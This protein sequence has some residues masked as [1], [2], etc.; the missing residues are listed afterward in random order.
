[1]K[2]LPDDLDILKVYVY[3]LG[4]K[5]RGA[6]ARTS[7]HFD[8]SDQ[9][10]SNIVK[11][12]RQTAPVTPESTNLYDPSSG[13]YEAHKAAEL[14]AWRQE[15]QR[16]KDVALLDRLLLPTEPELANDT[17]SASQSVVGIPEQNANGPECQQTELKSAKQPTKRRNA[18]DGLALVWLGIASVMTLCF[19]LA[20]MVALWPAVLMFCASLGSWWNVGLARRI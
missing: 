2:R 16:R 18:N 19:F 8:C 6:L 14:A 10:V 1:M 15:R 5:Q 12:H 7:R 13:A 3:E 17:D 9:H 4:Q 11:H 20:S